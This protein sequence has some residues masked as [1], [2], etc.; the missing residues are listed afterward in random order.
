[1]KNKEIEGCE[2]CGI[3]ENCN[4]YKI[5]LIEGK[6]GRIKISDF[7]EYNGRIEKANDVF[8]FIERLLKCSNC[9]RDFYDKRCPTCYSKEGYVKLEDVLEIIY[10]YRGVLL[11][12]SKAEMI[13]KIQALAQNHSPMSA[14][15]DALTSV[16]TT[17]TG[18]VRSKASIPNW[19]ICKPETL[20]DN[21]NQGDEICECG[22]DHI[23][24]D[25]GTRNNKTRICFSVG[26]KCTKFKPQ[27]EK[28]K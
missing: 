13:G 22:H 26:C 7:F 12:S 4:N 6:K 14:G 11:T 5:G 21:N 15:D 24:R 9:D 18:I 28:P 25:D 20:S 16:R 8:V 3:K 1:M 19:A 27:K 17:A 2:F 23:T 10:S